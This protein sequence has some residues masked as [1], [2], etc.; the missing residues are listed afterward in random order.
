MRF[1]RGV[2]LLACAWSRHVS[3]SGCGLSDVLADQDPGVFPGAAGAVDSLHSGGWESRRRH[4]PF[5]CP[6]WAGRSRSP[7]ASFAWPRSGIDCYPGR[8]GGVSLEGGEK[9][10]VCQ[11]R[12]TMGCLGGGRPMG[13]TYNTTEEVFGAKGG[14]NSGGLHQGDEGEDIEI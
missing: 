9:A 2:I 5:G 3:F 8:P 4:S 1:L 13:Y 14:R 10:D 11:G 12:W 7:D 6:P